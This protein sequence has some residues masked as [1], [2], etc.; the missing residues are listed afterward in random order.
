MLQ[1]QLLIWYAKNKRELPWRNT[2]DP[3]LI[4]LS[5]VILQQT[6][7]Q[8]GLPYY[9]KFTDKYQ[10][11]FELAQAPNEEIMKLW[12][13]LGY[14]SRARNMHETAKIISFEL[15]GK[16]PDNYNS[17]LKLRGIGPYTAAAIASFAFHEAVAVLDGNVYRVLSRLYAITDPIQS[18][19]GKK[20]FAAI[21]SD[22]LNKKDPALH[23]Q[24]M[25]ELGSLVCKPQNPNCLECPFQNKCLARLQNKQEEFPVQEKKRKAKNRYLHYFYFQHKGKTAIFRRVAGD[26]W[27]NLFD[28]PFLEFEELVSE[29]IVRGELENRDWIK[30]GQNEDLKMVFQ[31]KHLLTHQHLFA[32][33]WLVNSSK[34]PNLGVENIWVKPEKLKE[35]AVSRLLDKFLLHQKI[36]E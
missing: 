24:A 11:I 16:F 12:Q 30:N 19:Q 20:V 34:I 21:A 36:V 29:E 33:F 32:T 23:N 26:I 1:K 14:Y 3:Y 27:Q 18:G 9:Q 6:R 31:T 15:Q 35:Y 5:E 17:L 22:F 28:L 4:W 25:M 13:G 10:T 7:I 2:Q 8:Q